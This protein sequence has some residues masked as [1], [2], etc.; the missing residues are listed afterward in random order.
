M[1][2]GG[3]SDQLNREASLGST[4]TLPALVSGLPPAYSGGQ[5]AY[6]VAVAASSS[7]GVMSRAPQK[8]LIQNQSGIKVYYWADG[9]KVRGRRCREG[10]VVDS[11]ARLRCCLA[12]P[13][14]N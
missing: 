7:S 14:A 6:A 3:S 11:T 13:V 10:W 4:A 12:A 8:Y 9:G 2:L 5:A 1:Q